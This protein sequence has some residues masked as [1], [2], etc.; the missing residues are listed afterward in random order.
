[1]IWLAS[2]PRS[3]NT[4]FRNV[5]YEVYGL[6][7]STFHMEPNYPVDEGYEKYPV[8]KTHLLPGQLQPADPSIKKVYLVREGRDALVSMAHHRKDII[9]PGT[10]YYVNLLESILAMEGSFFGGWSE[11]VRQWMEVAD[12]VIRFEDLIADPIREVEKLRAIMDLPE[13]RRERLPT[14][15]DLKFGSPKYGAGRKVNDDVKVTELA[16]KNFRRGKTGSWR[17]EMPAEL[18]RLFWELHGDMMDRLGY[19][20]G[21]VGEEWAAEKR[22]NQGQKGPYRVLLEGNKATDQHMDGVRRYVEELIFGMSAFQV[23]QPDKWRFDVLV[24]GEI[25]PVLQFVEQMDQRREA[26]RRE[27][28]IS[29][30]EQVTM[31]HRLLAVK[32]RLQQWLP[33]PVYDLLA[34]VYRALP[35][36]AVL[37]RLR[38][39]SLEEKYIKAWKKAGRNHQLV[40]VPLPQHYF[41]VHK[42]SVPM[43]FTVHDMTHRLYPQYHERDNIR[44]AEE[45][46]RYCQER[47]SAL[48][49]VSESTR[50]DLVDAFPALAGKVHLVHE[51][52]N[53]D[54]FSPRRDSAQWAVV[55]ERYGIPEKPFLVSLSTLE[56][57][58]NLRRVLD[59]FLSVAQEP[60]MEDLHLLI[61]GRRGWKH[62]EILHPEHAAADRILFTGHVMD[63]DLPWLYSYA[64][65]LC[66]V[67]LYEGF[68]LPPLEAMRCGTPVIFGNN[69]SL[70]EVVGAAGL[71]ADAGDIASIAECM[72]RI[73]RDTGLRHSLAGEARAQALKFSWLKTS[74]QTLVQFE[75]VIRS[76]MGVETQKASV[77]RSPEIAGS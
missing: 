23:R 65:A 49:A 44:L 14:F 57:R 21:P 9:E 26:E 67:A 25:V 6:E 56:P 70:P 73:H 1:M 48:L 71:A 64:E 75:Q 40:H 61:C 54:H 76:T 47:G 43:V 33:R 13:P 36:R 62:D 10:D 16:R 4:F 74:F 51:A 20:K 18:E 7:S 15:E 22:S 34:P 8:V 29:G 31:D 3:G 27:F 19:P 5:L 53:A 69:S 77:S 38:G 72:R 24:D 68:G 60:G 30:P 46:M 63:D 2:F 66:Y 45:G 52:S 17:D 35:I 58:K 12:I 11:N 28:G 41:Y 42:L 39:D 50:K 37:R 32:A 55:R 59:A